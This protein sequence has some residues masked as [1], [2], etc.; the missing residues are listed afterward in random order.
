MAL[1][2]GTC[3]LRQQGEEADKYN[4]RE[5]VEPEVFACFLGVSERKRSSF[6]GVLPV[7]KVKTEIGK[8]S[9][10]YKDKIPFLPVIAATLL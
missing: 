3:D 4:F 10:F 6:A 8:N 2:E 9:L 5:S 1:R 7:P